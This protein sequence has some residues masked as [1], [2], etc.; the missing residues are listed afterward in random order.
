[1]YMEE[2]L[3]F[4]S[5]Q[6]GI[7]ITQHEPNG[8]EEITFART[9]AADNDIVFRWEGFDDGLILVAVISNRLAEYPGRAPRRPK[10]SRIP[11]KALDDDLLDIHLG[12]TRDARITDNH[13]L[14]GRSRAVKEK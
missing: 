9:I 6:M 4:L 12:H 3:S 8:R 7:G 10:L 11:F 13:A 14:R 2:S 1:M 5:A